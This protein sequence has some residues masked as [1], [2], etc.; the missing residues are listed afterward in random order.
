VHCTAPERHLI[1]KL[2]DEGK[3]TS[4]IAEL[5]NCSKKKVFSAV[6]YM[7]KKEN[8]GKKRAT[9]KWFDDIL[10]RTIK[11]Y[12]FLTAK[13]LRNTLGAAVTARTIRNRL[14]ER[15]LR[16]YSARKVPSLS[17]KNMKNRLLFAKQPEVDRLQR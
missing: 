2:S 1:K 13:E 15:D 6:H 14:I 12:P 17:Q 10:V 11:K 7:D 9:T 3:S 5:M 16:A 8:R 4:K